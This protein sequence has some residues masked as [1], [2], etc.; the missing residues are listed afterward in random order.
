MFICQQRHSIIATCVGLSV[1]VLSTGLA[2]AQ[3]EP[4]PSLGGQW[5]PSGKNVC[6]NADV[7]LKE[8]KNGSPIEYQIQVYKCA[9]SLF[10]ASILLD[11]SREDCLPGAVSLG[12]QSAE[13]QG[14]LAEL[15]SASKIKLVENQV[16]IANPEVSELIDL[17]VHLP[18]EST[19]STRPPD[20]KADKIGR[21]IRVVITPRWVQGELVN[22]I[23]VQKSETN[24]E[25]GTIIG[26]DVAGNAIL[27]Q[28][29][30]ETLLQATL[31][32]SPGQSMLMCCEIPGDGREFAE[33]VSV[34]LITPTVV[35]DDK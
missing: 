12:A 5:Q 35:D 13:V 30:P 31:K 26:T 14:I 11:E 21:R 8:E 4:T 18:G 22:F 28:P 1:F 17:D 24:P 3:S 25:I 34:L 6:L 20:G 16:V 33:E 29:I 10:A 15:T 9:E 23:D 2:L 32:C 19:D 27:S 7:E